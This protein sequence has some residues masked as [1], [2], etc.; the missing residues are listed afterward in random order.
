MAP[1]DNLSMT[2]LILGGRGQLAAA[3]SEMLADEATAIGR[4]RFDLRSDDPARLAEHAP[5]RVINCAAYNAV[6]AAEQDA[7][8]AAAINH[9]G[10]ERLARWCDASGVPLL[11]VSTDY[12]FSGG[13][14]GQMTPPPDGWTEA[15]RPQPRGVYASTKYAGEQAALDAGATAVRT[16]GLYGRG[17]GGVNVANRGG[18]FVETM[19]RLSESHDEV[20]VVSDQ[21][22]TPTA[23]PDLAG[24]IVALL[25][26]GQTGLFHATSAGRCTWAELAGELF[27]IARRD[28]R[29]VSITTADYGAP[30]PRPA[31]SVLSC[32]RLDAVLAGQDASP[33]RHW[34]DALAAYV[35][36]RRPVS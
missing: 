13:A 9:H 6:D 14:D 8:T 27:R 11:H 22:C 32:D 29:V 21:T 34:R 30:A 35:A 36:T 24:W 5:S 26:S 18:N 7:E 25:A 1:H 19:L 31:N 12:V 4:D 10:V 2:T 17:R 3:L 33:R 20:R 28:T 15:A 16:C 23:C